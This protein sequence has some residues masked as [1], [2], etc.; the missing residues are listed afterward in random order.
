MEPESP[1]LRSQLEFVLELDRLKTV[2]RRTLLLDES[3]RENSAEHSWHLAMMAVVLEEY[4]H[5]RV[6]LGRVLK[7]LL[8]HDIVEIDAGDTYS[9]DPV[10]NQ[11][12]HERETS[13]AARIFGLLPAEQGVELQ[14]LWLEFE[15][16]ETADA[17]F[18]NALDR[19]SPMLHN[20]HTNGRTW[21]AHGVGRSQVLERNQVMADGAPEL[22]EYARRFIEEAVSRGYLGEH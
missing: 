1:R 17:R 11:D 2:L 18:A 9:Y 21:L 8:V 16:R 19:L 20:Y 5:E 10:A 7:M 6:S 12:K 14:M 22:W 15:A 3:R 4:A 13:A